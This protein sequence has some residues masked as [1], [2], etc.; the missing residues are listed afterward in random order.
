MLAVVFILCSLA[1]LHVSNSLKLLANSCSPMEVNKVGRER[2]S[3][4]FVLRQQINAKDP[5]RMDFH[6]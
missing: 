2:V 5:T 6:F 3:K 4:R 1:N